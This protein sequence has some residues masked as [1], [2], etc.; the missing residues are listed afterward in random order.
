MTDQ[1]GIVSRLPKDPGVSGWAAI[2]PDPPPP[3][4]LED[5]ITAEWLV[6]GAGFAGLAAAHRLT[7]LCPGD[8]IVVLD[9]TRV[10]GGPAGRNS[11]FMIDLP[12]DLASDDYGGAVE[13]D[14]A[15]TRGNRCGIAFAA[16]MAAAYGLSPEAFSQSGKINGAASAKGHR[17]NLDYARHLGAM[18]EAHE[19]LDAAQMRAMTGTDYYVSGL[20][21]PGAAMIQPA[22]FVRGVAAGLASNR[23]AIHENTPVTSLT[24][25]GDWV[26]VTPRG[27]VRAPKVIL[28]VNGH[29]QSFGHM[30]G[31]LIH[32]HTYAAMTRAL[33]EGEAARLGGDPSWGLTPADPV[34]T[35]VRRISGTGGDR[36]VIRNRFTY[37]PTM[38]LPQGRVEAVGRD[39]D[40]AFAAR[41]PMLK[42]VGMEYRWGGRLC[43]SR[44][45]VQVI[46]ALE[47]GLFSA[48][49]QNGLGTAKGTL[50][51][52]LAAELANGVGSPELDAALAAPAPTRLP[53]ALVTRIGAAARLRWDAFRAGREY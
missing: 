21:T 11:G 18:G 2:L 14:Q 35:T 31:R 47:P 36:I 45:N 24:R 4:V 33:S 6:I 53:P 3:R 52:L 38:E 42:G 50:A 1:V 40:R 12:H 44:N 8:R 9:A 48:C 51:G 32:V 39:Q 23:V 30:A 25:D 20:R 34:G 29:L 13:A 7:Q 26:A 46:G 28:A 27:R 22:M 37:D 5:E 43:L 15:Q 41:F 10:G 16:E 17:H 19:M 49:C